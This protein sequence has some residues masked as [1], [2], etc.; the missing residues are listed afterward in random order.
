[1]FG[2]YL[3]NISPLFTVGIE[4]IFE[5][6]FAK[7]V[8]TQIPLIREFEMQAIRLAPM[9]HLKGLWD[10][11]MEHE[12]LAWHTIDISHPRRRELDPRLHFSPPA[13]P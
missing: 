6:R 1:L 10:P 11:P 9:Y 2:K 8:F 13:E 7:P 3:F 12:H 5:V 4:T